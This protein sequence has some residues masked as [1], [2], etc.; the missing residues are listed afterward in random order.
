MLSATRGISDAAF[1]ALKAEYPGVDYANV[2]AANVWKLDCSAGIDLSDLRSALSSC[3]KR[4]GPDVIVL[5]AP[6]DVTA[7]FAK[8]TDQLSIS[9]SS[10]AISILATGGGRVTLDANGLTRVLNVSAKSTLNLGGITVSGGSSDNGGGIYNAGTL[11]LDRVR[12][13]QNVASQNGGGIYNVGTLT[14]QN[15]LVEGNASGG[16]GGGIYS[17]GKY[18]KGSATIVQRVVNA[19]IA[20][21]VSGLSGFGF[22]GGVYFQGADANGDVFAETVFDNSIIVENRSSATECDENIYNALFYNEF[23]IDG[24]IYAFEEPI[25]AFID[26]SNNLSSFVYWVS[27]FDFDDPTSTGSNLLYNESIPLFERD[28]D[29]ESGEPGDYSLYVSALSQAIDKG[30]SSLATCPNGATFPLDLVGE[31]RIMGR[32]VDIGAYESGSKT[33][34]IV[35]SDSETLSNSAIVVGG[36]LSVDGIVVANDGFNETEVFALEFYAT[37]SGTIDAQAILLTSVDCGSL[38]PGAVAIVSSGNLPTS[39]LIPGKTYRIAW[40]AACAND[41]DE[42]NNFG[43][44][45]RSVSVYAQHGSLEDVLF[46]RESYST[47]QGDA[48]WLEAQLL[49]AAP[50]PRMYAFWFDFGDGVFVEHDNPGVVLSGEYPNEPGSRT[51]SVQVVNLA[52]KRVVGA[53]SAPLTVVRATPSF[54]VDAN[55]AFDGDALILNVEAIFT[56]P[57]AVN[58]WVFDWGDGTRT[59]L[60]KLGLTACVVHC[61]APGH[62]ARNVTLSVAIEGDGGFSV[63]FDARL[64]RR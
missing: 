41:V 6:N 62:K 24:D 5:N 59:E 21:N 22:G 9:D 44:A 60:D 8:A 26:G 61:Y 45:T 10:G 23:E 14:A 43:S 46:D 25:P 7:T 50:G 32:R 31:A 37:A 56:V 35:V 52:T 54:Q 64:L 30:D 47:R 28:P 29:L 48:F 11:S 53:G 36:A 40:R 17:S 12:V 13:S 57:N 2:S 42:S 1:D 33:T 3:A 49:S 63:S 55:S 58:R 39:G 34:D 16:H 20:G 18:S 15:V 51:I 27:S 19:T 4:S 38:A